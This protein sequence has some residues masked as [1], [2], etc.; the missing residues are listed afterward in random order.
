[1]SLLRS[2]I[3][4]YL[5]MWL[6]FAC[7]GSVAIIRAVQAYYRKHDS[8]MHYGC[9]A[10]LANSREHLA[11]FD[12]AFRR[13]GHRLP[14]V[15]RGRLVQPPGTPVLDDPVSVRTVRPAG[16]GAIPIRSSMSHP[17]DHHTRDSSRQSLTRCYRRKGA[18]AAVFTLLQV[19]KSTVLYR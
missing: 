11:A 12:A 3:P 9:M 2:I 8:N 19:G 10:R 15:G 4:D 7:H 1:M 6:R 5:E 16:P 14:D 13:F 18:G 17:A